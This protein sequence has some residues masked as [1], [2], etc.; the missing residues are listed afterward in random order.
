MVTVQVKA[1]PALVL[2]ICHRETVAVFRHRLYIACHC[3]SVSSSGWFLLPWSYSVV[4]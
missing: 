4:C 2:C 3:Y 1:S